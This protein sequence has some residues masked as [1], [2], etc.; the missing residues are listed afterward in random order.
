MGGS[1]SPRPRCHQHFPRVILH[2]FAFPVRFYVFSSKF[3][4]CLQGEPGAFP[5]ARACP[6]LDSRPPGDPSCSFPHV[7]P[8]DA[9]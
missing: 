8:G 3:C 9:F 2:F 6:R 1:G 4:L 5:S 7:S